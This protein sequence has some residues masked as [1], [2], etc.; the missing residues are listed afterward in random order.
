MLPA[1]GQLR[2][3]VTL[4]ASLPLDVGFHGQAVTLEPVSLR[5]WASN[6]FLV[7]ARS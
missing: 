6:S 2:L 5:V 7:L 4:P 1:T 3:P